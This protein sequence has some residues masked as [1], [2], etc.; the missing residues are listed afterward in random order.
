MQL[1][2]RVP[3]NKG[4]KVL[5]E[6]DEEEG[7]RVGS[8]QLQGE[9]AEVQVPIVAI[10][11]VHEVVSL[12]VDVDLGEGVVGEDRVYQYQIPGGI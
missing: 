3:A 12:V 1:P 5:L 2:V 6:G 10:K 7:G 4:K 9:A 11:W 8:R